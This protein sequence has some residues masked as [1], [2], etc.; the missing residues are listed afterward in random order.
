ML[1]NSNAALSLGGL[2]A[3]RVGHLFPR[4]SGGFHKLEACATFTSWKHVPLSQAGSL[5][6]F[7]GLLGV[8]GDEVSCS[9]DDFV[10]DAHV[11]GV[12]VSMECVIGS[13]FP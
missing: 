11:P 5:L 12:G 2:S 8:R 3:I 7:R 6:H 10:G 1:N 9:A 13:R 4:K